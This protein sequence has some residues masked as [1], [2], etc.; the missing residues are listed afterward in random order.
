MVTN[1]L[2]ISKA[3][4]LENKKDRF[5][6][7]FFEILPGVLAWGTLITVVTMSFVIPVAIAIFIIIFDVY[8]FVKTVYLS[9]HLRT[10][11]AQVRY[12]MT[13]DW[14]ERLKQLNSE[15]YILKD[16]DS[17]QKIYHLVLLP[18]YK[19]GSDVIG[20]AI[21]GLLNANYPKERMVVVI[22]QEERAGKDFN[23]A[24]KQDIESKYRDR[25]L[26]LDFVEHPADIPGELAGKGSN[27]AWSGKY[28]TKEIVD[29]MGLKY[30]HVLVSAFDVDTV[31]FREYFSRLTYAYLTAKDPV[32]SFYQPV[33]FYTNNI[34][35]A[36]SF[37]R[38]VAFSATFWHTI[39]QEMIET[40]TSFSS[41]TEP[42]RALVDVDFWQTNMVSEDSRIFWQCF[43]RYDGNYVGEALYYPVSMDANV[44]HSFW[45]TMINVYKQQRRWGYGVENLPYLLFNFHKNKLI[46]WWR[47]FIISARMLERFW[48]WATNAL[49]IFFLGWLPIIVGGSDFNQ[50]VLSFNLP[51]LT[52]I[53]MSVAMFGLITSAVF[54]IIILPPKPPR[55]GRF[56]YLWMILQWLI[57]PATTILLGSIPGLEA[58]TRLMFGKYMGF[59]VTPK[60]R[61]YSDLGQTEKD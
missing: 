3:S 53:I 23:A 36:P 60:V 39:K 13:V 4:D 58:Q 6:Y 42:L 15:K 19:E 5:L 9:L 52:R 22:G 50:S 55:Y 28:A 11:F 38:V 14:L 45:Q 2:K 49:L 57:F 1:Y 21:D 46:P 16:T 32:H 47:K 20:A 29:K 31:A 34:W 44:A 30:E 56:K 24:V 12:N 18:T 35:H 25:F 17:W 27:I 33:P 43:F 40:D 59:W 26:K 10:G 37:A 51:R 54:S 7:R 41:H 48:S 61:K 8:W